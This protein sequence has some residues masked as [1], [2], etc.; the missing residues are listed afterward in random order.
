MTELKGRITRIEKTERDGS[1]FFYLD[2]PS[3][4]AV[5]QKNGLVLCKGFTSRITISMPVLMTGRW[6]N[7]TFFAETYE[8]VWISNLATIDFLVKN[9]KGI[10]KKTAG[11]IC[12]LY[13][14]SLFK[15]NKEDLSDSLQANF[16]K[17]SQEQIRGIIQAIFQEKQGLF[18]LETLF[19][20]LSIDYASILEIYDTYGNEALKK[21]QENPYRIGLKFELPFPAVDGIAY[22]NGMDGLDEKRIVG[23]IE[24]KLKYAGS[25]GHT[26]VN[27]KDLAQAVTHAS[28]ISR[29]EE[30]IPAIYVSSVIALS[31]HIT[32]EQGKISINKYIYAEKEIAKRLKCLS[33]NPSKITIDLQKIKEISQ[34]IG[35][36][37]GNDQAQAFFLLEK[38]DL[39]ILTGGPG[40]GKTTT[41]RGIAEYYKEYYPN[42]VIAFCAPTGRAA[43]RLSESTGQPATTIHKLLDFKPYDRENAGCKNQSNPIQADFIIVDEMSMVDAELMSLLLDAVKNGTKLLLV[44][45]E[46]Q[47]PSIGPGNILHDMIASGFFPVCRLKENFRQ[48]N[49]GSIYMNSERILHGKVPLSAPDFIIQKAPDEKAAY[50]IL[51]DVMQRNYDLKN[52]FRIQLIAPSKKGTA[53]TVRMNQ[54]VHSQVVHAGKENIPPQPMCGDKIMFTKTNYEAGYINGDVGIIESMTADKI[55]VWN[56]TD[57]YNVPATAI[58]DMT[59]AYAYTIHKSQGSENDLILIYLPQSMSHMMTRSLLYTAVTRARRGVYI[60]YTD[61]AL[62]RCVQN[63]TG[64]LRQTRLLEFLAN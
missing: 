46:N 9:C 37:F 52:P 28:E 61:D 60:V 34:K 48:A 64:N 17:L 11:V 42:A 6:E 35:C 53:G 49:E 7:G 10:G 55:T 25:S 58:H 4:Q 33:G 57:H 50:Q 54:F 2:T 26:F 13:G 40:T 15:R 16:P 44:G 39:M 22:N 62:N 29:F 47:L 27:A 36:D 24:Y 30:M 12:S 51:C 8:V 20:Q 19:S 14:K 21:I 45:D 23:L 63:T 41:V 18:E 1:C 31:K 59:L 5:R 38:S 43:Q 56:G 32:N 3:I